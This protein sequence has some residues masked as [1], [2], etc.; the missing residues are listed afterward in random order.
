MSA[1]MSTVPANKWAQRV[2]R[3][4]AQMGEDLAAGLSGT[5]ACRRL[6][7]TYDEIV[8]VLWELALAEIPAAWAEGF[9]LVALGGWGREEICPYSDIDF[10][11]LADGKN[12]TVA[13]ELAD[14]I[15]Y[16]LWD[17]RVK[18]GHAVRSSRDA[19][20]LARDDLPTATALLDARL[21][22][23]DPDTFA[24]LVDATRRSVA[25]GGNANHFLRALREE[26]ERRYERYGESLYLLEPNIKQ[27]IGGLRDYST[28]HWAARAR[29]CVAG[30]SDLVA[31]G[32]LTRRQLQVMEGGLDFL[33]QIRSLVQLDAGRLTDQLTFEIQESIGPALFPYVVAPEGRVVPA[34]APAVET[35]MRK[36]YLAGR[37]I[38]R[39][40]NRLL[41]SATVPAR[42]K[43]HI[44]K[45]DRSFLSWNGKLAV[46]DPAIFREQPA[47]MF[48][49]FRVALDLSLPLY[50]HTKELIEAQVAQSG[51]S[52]SGDPKASAFFLEALTDLRDQGQGPGRTKSVLEQMHGLGLL[53]AIMPEFGY[54]TGRVQHD[55]YHVY[56]VDQHQLAAVGLLKKTGSGML[57]PGAEV[58]MAAYQRLDTVRSLYLATLLHDVGKP[59]G[60]GH[61]ENGAK[62]A[63]GIA[64]N[65]GLAES[66]VAMVDFLVRQ[67]LTMSHISQRRDLS[68]P[69]VIAKFA[70]LVG[71]ASALTR[72]Y[73]LTRC[74]TAMTA[75]GNLSSWKDQLLSELYL[76]TL[77]E[78][79]G[80]ADMEG[81][82][83]L[84]RRQ[85]RRRAVEIVSDQG[86]NPKRAARA[87]SIVDRLDPGFVN[88]L[89]ARQL[90]RIVESVLARVDE[91]V[92]V[93]V[94][95]QLL[96]GR[97]Q[98][99]FI[100]V[101]EDSSSLLSHVAGVLSAHRVV[102]DGAS[103]TSLESL[104]GPVAIQV[105]M[106]RDELDRPIAGDDK[107]WGRVE[108]DLRAVMESE[109]RSELV[110]TLLDGRSDGFFAKPTITVRDDSQVKIFD[111]ESSD[112]SVVEVHTS[113]ATALLHCITGIMGGHGL[114]IYRALISTE[115]DRVADV[116]YVQCQGQKLSKAQGEKLR[117][118]LFEGLAA[119]G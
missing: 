3:A 2:D 56:T 14:K 104:Q 5:E 89:S 81:E 100:C 99:E 4:R 20:A 25:P 52:L 60:A 13:K 35:L 44:H 103:T 86:R 17:A 39:I 22:V 30:L 27:G 29:W 113:D 54:C 41:E 53:A 64:I 34:V 67:H 19:A 84:H 12:D 10:V 43:P 42:R 92:R 33:L 66:E 116:F 40:A 9:A 93:F 21:V 105:F 114:D 11:I 18:V 88:T 109:N 82:Q 59:L 50:G 24:T 65:L 74:D 117:R 62:I 63:S 80:D 95:T 46:R 87:D 83:A 70:S 32:E 69:D 73:L 115:G 47:E 107:R 49:Y 102:I 26:R 75:P 6:S 51:Y 76:R 23:G 119:L 91:K 48:R 96:S 37:G 118:D 106:V 58:A 68:D 45:I 108:R 110:Q 79:Q 38:E 55:L 57:G 16:P 94:R 7:Q 85:A 8:T 36:Y 97:G 78:L 77:D 1:E 112:Y 31:C 71:S 28:A 111:G 72:L 61:A 101:S 98:T 90:S 15:L